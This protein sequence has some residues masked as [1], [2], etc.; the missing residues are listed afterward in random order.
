MFKIGSNSSN[1]PGDLKR[2]CKKFGLAIQGNIQFG[3]KD[4]GIERATGKKALANFN[5]GHFSAA[6]I[7][8]KDQIFRVRLLIDIHFD[9]VHSAIFQ[10]FLGATAIHA[11]IR[12]IHDDLIHI[13]FD[14]NGTEMGSS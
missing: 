2:I 5:R 8:F 11:P 12:A 4:V 14:F 9:E 3:G 13:I 6:I 7:D 1:K 10:K